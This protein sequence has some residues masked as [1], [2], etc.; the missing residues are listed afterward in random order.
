MGAK[1]LRQLI[2]ILSAEMPEHN[3]VSQVKT[4]VDALRVATGHRGNRTPVLAVG[5]DGIT[6]CEYQHPF[7]EVATTATVTIFDHVGK[8]LV[9]AHLA[10]PPELGQATMSQMMMNLLSEVFQRWGD[11]C[12]GGLCCRLWL[13]RK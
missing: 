6:L 7:W 8:R 1:R 4:L 11:R 13:Q 5:R 3:Q 9:T 12:Q 10:H 2:G